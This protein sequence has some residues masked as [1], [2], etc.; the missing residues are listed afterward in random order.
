MAETAIDLFAPPRVVAEHPGDG[1]P[2]PRAAEP[3]RDFAPSMAH[4][5]RA[6]ADAHP[7]RMLATRAGVALR[8][9]EARERADAVAQAL[10][11]LGLGPDR[12]LM[13]LSGNS[14]EHLLL[15]LGAYTGAVPVLPV[16]P[17]YSLL[18]ADHARLRAIAA[19]CAPGAVFAD[20]A[21]AFGG[22]L[23]ALVSDVPVQIVARGQRAGAVAFDELV[24]AAP[25]DAVDD[26]LAA[27]G[28]ESVAKILFTS[29]STGAPKGVLNTHRMLCSN[30][31]ALGQVW[32]FVRAEPPVLV[33]WLPWSHTFGA[34]HNLNQVLAFGGTLHIDDGKPVPALFDRTVRALR[35]TRPT[36][37]YNVPAGY[38]L[39]APRLEEDRDFAAAFFSRLR[40]MFYAA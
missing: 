11:D 4:A 28:P 7:E 35:E 20:D 19:L 3:L 25:T 34:N 33:D 38:A 17:A 36:V 21:A 40:F 10:L 37:Y 8:W 26:A 5:F 22:A 23:D 29:G 9:G 2:L 31:Q 16:S 32:P 39:L 13:V 18:S 6:G 14:L 12:P 27:L 24:A 15:T 30:Q 1:A